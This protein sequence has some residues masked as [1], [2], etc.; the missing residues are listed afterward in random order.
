M[1]TYFPLK[2]AVSGYMDNA[3]TIE[4]MKGDMS[5]IDTLREAVKTDG[6]AAP[7]TERN[8]ENIRDVEGKIMDLEKKWRF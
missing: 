6:I 8:L 1:R 5:R 3:P 4:A 2:G 7:M